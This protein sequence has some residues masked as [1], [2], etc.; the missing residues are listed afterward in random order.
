[1]TESD[2]PPQSHPPPEH[3]QPVDPSPRS[4]GAQPGAPL[5]RLAVQ[6]IPPRR[7][8]ENDASPP[9]RD[10]R[11]R[12]EDAG[13]ERSSATF[14]TEDMLSRRPVRSC[15]LGFVLRLPPSHDYIRRDGSGPKDGWAKGPAD[16]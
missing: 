4:T 7:Q 16:P 8:P 13:S 10:G 5:H 6:R 3:D 11:L 2:P 1:M 14:A 15:G 9:G 12:E